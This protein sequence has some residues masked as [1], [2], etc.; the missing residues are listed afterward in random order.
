MRPHSNLTL[1]PFVFLFFLLGGGGGKT[2]QHNQNRK[3]LS[4]FF[5]LFERCFATGKTDR[6]RTYENKKNNKNRDKQHVSQNPK[7]PHPPKRPSSKPSLVILLIFPG[8][9]FFVFLFFPL[10]PS[11]FSVSESQVVMLYQHNHVNKNN[12]QQQNIRKK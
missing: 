8:I 1:P 11:F 2:K 5:W 4:R 9:P 10:S 7:R 6:D 12:E 3:G